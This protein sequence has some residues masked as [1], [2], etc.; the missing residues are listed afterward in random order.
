MALW[1]KPKFNTG[2]DDNGITS[3]PFSCVNYKHRTLLREKNINN[4]VT[5]IHTETYTCGT[6]VFSFDAHIQNIITNVLCI[7]LMMRGL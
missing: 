4:I 6:I 5:V 7:M 2:D 1:S 3:L